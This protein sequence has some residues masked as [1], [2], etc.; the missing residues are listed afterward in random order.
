M[1]HGTMGE[2]S[3]L[4][5]HTLTTLFTE[6]STT[7]ESLKDRESIPLPGEVFLWPFWAQW[8]T[9]E[10]VRILSQEQKR[11]SVGAELLSNGGMVPQQGRAQLSNLTPTSGKHENLCRLQHSLKINS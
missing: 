6:N 4:D 8:Y 5:E 2:Q 1:A 9:G 3:F 7:C 11:H 10:R